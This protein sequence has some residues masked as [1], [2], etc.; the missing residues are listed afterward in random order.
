VDR[1][2]N[3]V[4][5]AKERLE[6]AKQR[7]EEEVD[8]GRQRATRAVYDNAV[9]AFNMARTQSEFDKVGD[10]LLSCSGGKTARSRSR[11]VTKRRSEMFRLIAGSAVVSVVLVDNRVVP[12]LATLSVAA[13]IAAIPQR[14]RQ[15]KCDYRTSPSPGSTSPTT[16]QDRM[17]QRERMERMERERAIRSGT[18]TVPSTR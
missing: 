9:L 13:V 1:G 18:T 15:H 7:A 11:A 3:S 14:Q 10:A 4:D 12:V 5:E 16:S 6:E 8:R 17:E 2:I